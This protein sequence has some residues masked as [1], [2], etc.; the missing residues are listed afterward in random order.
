M[1]TEYYNLI[2][3][4]IQ[5]V[6]IYNAVILGWKVKKIGYNKYELSKKNIEPTKFKFN[7]FITKIIS[8][9]I[10]NDG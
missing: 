3:Y 6:S 1:E 8:C 10:I 7:D 5:I 9:D 4:I 2:L